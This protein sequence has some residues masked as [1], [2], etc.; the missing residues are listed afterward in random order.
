MAETESELGIETSLDNLTEL[1]REF[2]LP[3]LH[4]RSRAKSGFLV[5][6]NRL[7]GYKPTPPG[8]HPLTSWVWKHGEPITRVFDGKAFWLCRLCYEKP[9]LQGLVLKSAKST[10]RPADHLCDPR[11]HNRIKQHFSYTERI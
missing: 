6:S 4:A 7:R 8:K 11:Y 5:D 10:N 2:G 3:S 1:H 9:H